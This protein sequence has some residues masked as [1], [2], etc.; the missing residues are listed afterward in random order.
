MNHP[1]LDARN[2]VTFNRRMLERLQSHREDVAVLEAA[3]GRALSKL[4]DVLVEAGLTGKDANTS[5]ATPSEGGPFTP[6][7]VARAACHAESIRDALEAWDSLTR[8]AVDAA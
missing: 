4:Q 3:Q 1:E 2:G 8:P 7:W 5:M 6:Q